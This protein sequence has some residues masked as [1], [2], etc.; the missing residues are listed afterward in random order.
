MSH[1]YRIYNNPR[2]KKAQRHN[3]DEEDIHPLLGVYM[4]YPVG[5]PLTWRS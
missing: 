3:L 4:F 1:T 2:I 5:I